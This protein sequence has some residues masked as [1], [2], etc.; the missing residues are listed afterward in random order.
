MNRWLSKTVI[1]SAA[2]LIPCIG[3]LMVTVT[4][5]SAADS[6]QA[7]PTV[8]SYCDT[9]APNFSVQTCETMHRTFLSQARAMWPS[10]GTV[11][12]RT[13]AEAIVDKAMSAQASQTSPTASV[14]SDR[15][16]VSTYAYQTSYA[17]AGQYMEA[18][19]SLVA[20]STPVWVVTTTWS[21]PYPNPG[22]GL[23]PGPV[24]TNA[25]QTTTIIDG[26]SGNPIDACSACDVVQENGIVAGQAGVGPSTKGT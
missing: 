17:G 13:R 19:N 22:M 1:A 21:A 15:T 12:S 25:N 14:A 20:P 9:A 26:I 8:P 11:M 24:P 23:H 3:V 10:T 5:A 6:G 18:T 2:V 4:H 16:P 7:A